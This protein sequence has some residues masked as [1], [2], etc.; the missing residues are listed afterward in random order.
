MIRLFSTLLFLFVTLVFTPVVSFSQAS[1]V[2]EQMAIKQ[3]N[4]L[5]PKEKK[6][7]LKK[8]DLSGVDLT[9]LSPVRS[10]SLMR[11]GAQSD[12]RDER[13]S[14]SVSSV[15]SARNQSLRQ[16]LINDPSSGQEME[17]VEERSGLTQQYPLFLRGLFSE[18]TKKDFDRTLRKEKKPKLFG[19]YDL[20]SKD[21]M[22]GPVDDYVKDDESDQKESS[23]EDIPENDLAYSQFGYDLF[24]N[25]DLLSF[26]VSDSPVG[27]DYFL[28]PGD[29]V[30]IYVWGKLEQTLTVALDKKGRLYWPSLGHISLL[31]VKL[32]NAD[33]VIHQRLKE[34]YVNFQVTVSLSQVRNIRIYVLGD[35]VKPGAYD[36]TALGNVFHALYAAGGPKDIGSLRRV[37]LIRNQ[38][39]IKEIDLYKYLLRGDNRHDEQLRAYDSIFV[40]PIGDVVQVKGDVKRQGIYELTTKTM[41]SDIL[42]LAGGYTPTTYAKKIQIKRISQGH[43]RKLIDVTLS[44][45]QDQQKLK[46]F[47]VYNGD[48]IT[49]LSVLPQTQSSVSIKGHV[50]REG[51]YGFSKGMSLSQ[52]IVSAEGVKPEAYLTRIDILRYVSD[53][54]REI[55]SYDLEK[56]DPSSILLKEWDIVT[57]YSKHDIVGQQSVSIEGEIVNPG[58]YKLLK[59]MRVLDLVFQGRLKPFANRDQLELYRRQLG[60]PP[61]IFKISLKSILNNPSVTQNIELQDQDHILIRKDLEA[62]TIKYVEISGQ[63]LFPGKYIAKKGDKLSD[64]ITRAGGFTEQAF[65]KGA[66]FTR[67]SAKKRETSG[68]EKVLEDERKRYIYDKSHLSG[69]TQNTKES[70]DAVMKSRELSLDHLKEEIDKGKG[71]IILN[72]RDL[73]QFKNSSSDI[74]I[75][76]GDMLMIPEV[77]VSVNLIGGI[78][79]PTSLL[80]EKNKNASYYIDRVGG[81]SPYADKSRVLVFK[82]NGMVSK[83]QNSIEF[84]DTIYVPEKLKIPTNW[85]RFVSNIADILGNVAT[86]VAA[87]KLLQ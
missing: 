68:H 81:F 45:V 23:K 39:V 14:R 32:G 56:T 20:F 85:L 26:S 47:Q 51:D 65:L 55:V 30:T 42:D 21:S 16:G 1:S 59:G 71:R 18:D 28:G 66:V 4:M 53:T 43:S 83:N 60:K 86:G 82:P 35:V 12:Q 27:P 48:I 2:K 37:K 24:E 33:K 8:I 36:M 70:N 54:N 75:E 6:A 72:L 52:L 34:K 77:P 10:D 5:S 80:Y 64:V 78:E 15:V 40:P 29:Q 73:D 13:G 41:L 67:E 62:S 76:D 44:S 22:E 7:L 87:V 25:N 50:F 69:L 3:F 63:V 11:V 58:Q 9:D 61:E 17:G 49:V 46:S 38:K 74:E 84:G 79:N 57:L 19:S 31:G